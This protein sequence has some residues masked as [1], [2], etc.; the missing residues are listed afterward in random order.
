MCLKDRE[1]Y[2]EHLLEMKQKEKKMLENL[3]SGRKT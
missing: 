1:F 2:Y 3:R